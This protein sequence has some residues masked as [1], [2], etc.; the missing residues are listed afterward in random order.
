VTAERFI[1]R[2]ALEHS[3][4]ALRRH[5]AGDGLLDALHQVIAA[6]RALF[7]ASGAGIMMVDDDSVLAAVAAT[8][9]VGR[10][11][12]VRQQETGGGPC[13]DAL[14]FDRVVSTADLASDERWPALLPELPELGVRSVLGIPLHAT[15]V[16]IGSLNVYRDQP[17]AW[18]DSEVSALEAY[19]E[20]VE[21]LL[22]S[23]LQA[24]EHEQLAAQLQ[25]ALD[26]RVAIER[27]V[28]VVMGRERINAVAA[29]NRLR[30]SARS[31][32]RK[33]ADVAAELLAE[34]PGNS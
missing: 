28:G 2:A 32:G 33:V 5:S 7:D 11:L 23:A 25:Y 1:D 21:N 30:S 34:I 12:E 14:T 9:D 31:T 13:V 10:L 6:T 19:A 16:P 29:F 22:G 4:A 20:L 3:L 27:A 8:D 24:Q 18:S 15:R 17:G 26:T